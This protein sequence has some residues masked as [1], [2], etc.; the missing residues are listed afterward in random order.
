MS[1]HHRDGA[2]VTVNGAQAPP[3]RDRPT[4]GSSTGERDDAGNAGRAVSSKRSDRTAG[5]STATV[6]LIIPAKNEAANIS[7]VLEQVPPCV[8]EVIL[9][10]GHS[11]DATLV[12]ARCARP[13]IR[14]VH[15]DGV[16]KGD[17]LRAG[18]LASEADIVVMMDAD[19]SMSPQELP[20]FL[21]F[22]AT[23]YDFVK[24]SRFMAGGG[25]QDI[26]RLRRWGNRRLVSMVNFLYEEQ[27][28]DLCY[29]FCA[30]HRRYLPF[31]DLTSAGFEVETRLTLS[32][33]AAGLR[34]AE[35]PSL[36]MPRR[37]GRSNLRTLPDGVRVLR[38]ILRGHPRGI[39]GR[40]IEASTSLHRGLSR[41]G[42]ASVTS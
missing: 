5:A 29:G 41:R 34:V 6:A 7:W 30:F 18:F 38:S 14:I 32:A 8:D 22:L 15:Q 13:G 16:G 10:D 27:L 20:H 1:N 19:C 17:A 42:R 33:L 3:A 2:V 25:S 35:V 23:G 12:T 40:L 9:V 4:R 39:S 21:H 28:T 31:L 11:T 36:E 26:T 37:H 24:G